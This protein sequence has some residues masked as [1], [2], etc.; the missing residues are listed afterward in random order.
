MWSTKEDKFLIDCLL[1]LKVEQKW[2]AD[3]DFKAG[4]ANALQS[5]MEQKLPGYGIKATPHITS[6]IKTLKH[7][8]QMAYDMVYGPNTSGFEQ[9]CGGVDVIGSRSTQAK[10]DWYDDY[11]EATKWKRDLVAKEAKKQ[12]R[13]GKRKDSTGHSTKGSEPSDN[14]SGDELENSPNKKKQRRDEVQ[15][16]KAVVSESS[17]EEEEGDESDDSGQGSLASKEEDEGDQ[18]DDS[19]QASTSC[20]EGEKVPPSTTEPE[21]AHTR[22]PETEPFPAQP[23]GDIATMLGQIVEE[24]VAPLRQA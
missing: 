11:E 20:S 17:T 13:V 6:R 9:A 5:M 1:T 3:N 2:M 10:N 14:A 22:A 8:W 19:G 21:G 4:F 7:L 24:K 12:K 18:S 16:G 23:Y 15:K